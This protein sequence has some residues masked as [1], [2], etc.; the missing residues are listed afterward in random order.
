MQ[1]FLLYRCGDTETNPGPT[2][3]KELCVAHINARSFRN[4]MDLLEAESNNF[5]IITLSETWLSHSHSN[6]SIHL[7][8]FHEPIRLLGI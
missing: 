3:Q 4:K 8:N 7:P 2:A 5:D 1:T 6:S